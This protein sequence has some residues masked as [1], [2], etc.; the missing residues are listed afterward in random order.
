MAINI[1]KKKK[2]EEKP[3]EQPKEK[4][5]TKKEKPVSHEAG[6][7]IPKK[8]EKSLWSGPIILK[9]LHVTEKATDFLKN[10]QYI[11]KVSSQTNKIEIKKSIEAL[12][13]VNVLSV[14]IINVPR[15]ARR[16]GGQA[17]WRQGYKKAIVKIPEGQKIEVL[18]R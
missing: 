11:F 9:S 2:T 6:V 7:K 15:K 13:G 3:A 4:K 12:Y 16:M 8:K 1:F 17:G 14:K 10:N 5:E 18:A